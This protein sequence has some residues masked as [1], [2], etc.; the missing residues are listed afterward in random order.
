MIESDAMNH[1]IF[2]SQ[3]LVISVCSGFGALI[4]T[5]THTLLSIELV[6]WWAV[7][8]MGAVVGGSAA[9]WIEWIEARVIRH[10]SRRLISNEPRVSG[11]ESD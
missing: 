2:A 10:R 5:T 6:P 7:N 4:C 9:L 1:P 11:R 3:I 8:V